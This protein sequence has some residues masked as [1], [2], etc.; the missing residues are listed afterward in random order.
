MGE[1]LK[2]KLIIANDT[3]HLVV[4][5]DFISG[6]A[7]LSGVAR[8]D[9]NKIIL[10]VDEAVTNIVEHGFDEGLYRIAVDLSGLDYISSAGAGVFIG[11]IGTAQDNDG[12]IVLLQ[13]TPNV[14]EVFDLLGFSQIFTFKD[15]RDDAM[16]ALK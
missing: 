14:K 6:V 5:R 4:V 1:T 13:P 15:S 8:E 9:E 3:K 2:D 16:R 10:A 11:T 12:N 7:R